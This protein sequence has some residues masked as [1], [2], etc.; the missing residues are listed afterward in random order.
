MATRRRLSARAALACA[1]LGA[2]ACVAGGGGGI[3]NPLKPHI[4]PDAERRMGDSADTQLRGVL[5]LIDDPV[6]LG[7]L[8][9]LGQSLVRHV[10]PQPFVYRFRIVEDP[11]LNAFALPGGYIYF[12]TGTILAA[13]DVD[14]LAG[15][16]AH[17]IAHAKRSH[18]ARLAEKSAIPSLLASLLGIGAAVATGDP[19]AAIVA[20]GINQS[21]ML[22]YTREVET[23]A[24]SVGTVFMVRAGY[25][26]R[27]MA[28]FF[29]RLLAIKESRPGFQIPPY[30]MSHPRTELRLDSAIARA[31]ATTITGKADPAL[32]AQFP[33]VQGRLG[34]LLREGRTTLPS[35]RRAPDTSITTPALSS[36]ET[37]VRAGD[38]AAAAAL[39]ADAGRREPND[40]RIAFREAELLADLGRTS[41]AIAA[42]RRALLLDPEVALSYY[43]IGQL[44]QAQGDRVNAVFY[45]EQAERRFEA[46]GLLEKQTRERINRLTFPLFERSGTS[47]GSEPQTDAAKTPVGAARDEFRIATA[48]VLWFGE[49][50][51][52]WAERAAELSVRWLD[53]SGTEVARD[54]E[55][56]RRGRRV[57]SSELAPPGGFSKP[58]IW[59]I[60]VL[61][62]GERADRTTFRVTP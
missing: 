46:G 15:V 44:Y 42:Y 24:D 23:E 33:A 14:E 45:L 43:R 21:M 10:E 9:D 59:Q 20:Q 6:A 32:A 35:F 17:E 1:L 60:E 56:K 3:A 41:D 40:P 37:L 49:L 26:P 2:L 55:L 12:H 39:L 58:G 11:T 22:A 62:A 30:L 36:A 18:M 16:M 8:N 47:D 28:D 31:R 38:S 54:D 48:R 53:P 34:L 52:E 19:A 51:D 13:K 7:F 5:P 57:V 29:D 61:L 4:T 27:G 25:D 50:A